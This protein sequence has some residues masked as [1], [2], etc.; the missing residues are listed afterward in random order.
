MGETGESGVPG[1]MVEFGKGT[2]SGYLVGPS[3]GGAAGVVVLQEWWGLVPHIKDVCGRLAGEGY[4][5]LAPDLYHGQ[6]TVEAAEA[7]HLMEGLD[8]GRAVSEITAAVGYLRSQGCQKVGIVG[9][10]MGGALS[11]LGSAKTS[12]AAVCAFYGFPPDKGAVAGACAPTQ[13]FFGEHEDFFSVP[14]AQA[15]AAKQRG[16]GRESAVHV[17]PGAG[18][19][20]Y[21]DTRPEAYHEASA[22]D[23]WGKA[24]A[25]F[26][27]HLQA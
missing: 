20:F 7:Q 27:R 5:A 18:H 24:L 22:K 19:A 9:F 15:W 14:D 10:C 12:A 21:N 4:L 2:A 17:Y 1:A 6:S 16:L 3:G 11:V 25:H 13:I 26:S 23:A 8:W